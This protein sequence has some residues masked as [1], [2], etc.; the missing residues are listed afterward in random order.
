M[1][2][3]DCAELTPQERAGLVAWHLAR[4]RSLRTVEVARLVGL[5]ERG[6]RALLGR[7]SRILPIRQDD[8]GS[9]ICSNGA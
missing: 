7:L 2:A 9:W 1:P 8:S 4:G 5:K 3:L 6:A